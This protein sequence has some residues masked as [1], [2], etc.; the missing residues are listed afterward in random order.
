M[1]YDSIDYARQ[2]LDGTV[3]RINGEV[4]YLSFR[5][6]WTYSVYNLSSKKEKNVDIR[7][8]PLDLNPIPLGYI[9]HGNIAYYTSRRPVRR[10]KQGLSS[11]A[12][13]VRFQKDGRNLGGMMA[14]TLLISSG[15]IN[16]VDNVYPSIQESYIEI[17]EGGYNSSAF[18]RAFALSS[19]P[20][21]HKVLDLLYKNIKVGYVNQKGVE[22]ET[23]FEYLKEALEEAM[24]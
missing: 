8:V 7:K 2:R 21:D 24:K 19:S 12:L 22:L 10:W 9:N 1:K 17:V 11:D 14:G 23:K 18:S 20:V 13:D 15:L 4:V 16:C 3:I 6:N 5:E